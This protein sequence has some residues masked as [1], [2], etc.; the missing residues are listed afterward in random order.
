MGAIDKTVGAKSHN[1][2]FMLTK[3]IF[4]LKMGKHEPMSSN[5]NVF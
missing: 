4:A 5:I 3:Q 2:K 1:A